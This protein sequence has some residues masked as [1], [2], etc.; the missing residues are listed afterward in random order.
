MRIASIKIVLLENPDI[1]C[2]SINVTRVRYYT[3]IKLNE[4]VR[5]HLVIFS[6]FSY[7]KHVIS[8]PTGVNLLRNILKKKFKAEDLLVSIYNIHICVD[9]GS[10]Y[11]IEFCIKSDMMK[12]IIQEGESR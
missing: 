6:Y 5:T 7:I 1:F 2:L 12:R 11:N 3:P 9:I 4:P 10:I 8:I